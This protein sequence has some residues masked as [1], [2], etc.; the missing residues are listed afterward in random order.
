MIK[1]LL[2]PA[3]IFLLASASARVAAQPPAGYYQTAA[4]K[5]GSSLKTAFFQIIN[6]YVSADYDGFTALYWGNNYFKKT[7]WNGAGF[8]WDMYSDEQRATYNSSLMSRE[9]CMPRSWW[10]NAEGYGGANSDLHNLY[11]SDYTANSKKSNLPL[12][13]AGVVSWTNGVSRVG[14]NVYPGYEGTIFEPADEYKGDF[15]RT[16]FYMVTAHEDYADRWKNDGLASMLQPGTYPV[17]Q[18]WAIGMLLKW[19]RQ[20]PVSQKETDRNDAVF[21]IQQNRNPFIDFPDLYEY[22]W[23]NRMTEAFAVPAPP[24]SPALIT[25]QNGLMVDFGT[26]K[27]SETKTKTIPVRSVLLTQ[28]LLL[29]L[30]QNQSGFFSINKTAVNAAESNQA[31]GVLAAVSYTPLSAGTHTAVLKITDTAD[32]IS[33]SVNLSAVGVTSLMVDPVTPADDDDVLFFY[34]GPWMKASLPANFTTNIS[35]AP[36][37]NGD[38]KFSKS[39]DYLTFT[40]TESPG[41]MRFAIYPRNAWGANANHLYVYEGT[42]EST[43]GSIPVADFDNAFITV[44]DSYNNTP[45]IPLRENTRA[46]KIEYQ[47]VAQNVGIT[48]LFVTR[49]ATTAINESDDTTR[50]QVATTPDGVRLS[51]LP[52]GVVISV[53]SL[54][55][56]TILKTKAESSELE[57]SVSQRGVYLVRIGE[58]CAKVIR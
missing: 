12:G 56:Q 38:L 31:G 27:T 58:W 14:Q 13:E 55:G 17:F 34:Q 47:K 32:G 37:S 7:D 54:S 49:R 4:G 43:I 26:V 36:Y 41:F 25:P 39:K 20:D 52:L 48:N 29:S 24:A 50:P 40:F 10:E 11:P 21:A 30:E 57:I 22:I 16:Y 51:H 53:H 8:F 5:S 18:D 23:G 1:K 15:A 6:Q 33:S 9:H 35:T 44:G 46:V 45:P 19:A 3:F 28:N 42:S 2:V